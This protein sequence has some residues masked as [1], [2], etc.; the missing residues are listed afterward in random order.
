MN[1]KHL[2]SISAKELSKIA[3]C[4][5]SVLTPSTPTAYQ[6]VRIEQGNRAHLQFQQSASQFT[7]NPINLRKS[8]QYNEHQSPNVS[9]QHRGKQAF[10]IVSILII[11]T[12]LTI[13]FIS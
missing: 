6:Q 11:V 5:L 3:Y 9:S 2:P 7:T 4:E 1:N 10:K 13:L 12:I 8:D